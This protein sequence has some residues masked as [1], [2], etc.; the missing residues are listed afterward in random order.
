MTKI[1]FIAYLSLFF[2]IILIINYFRI[3]KLENTIGLAT[4]LPVMETTT[5]ESPDSGF[6]P[7]FDEDESEPDINSSGASDENSYFSWLFFWKAEEK[8][9]LPA[10]EL[11]TANFDNKE[12]VIPSYCLGARETKGQPLTTQMCEA[13]MNTD[14]ANI[15]T[16]QRNQLQAVLPQYSTAI[17]CAADTYNNLNLEY[18]PDCVIEVNRNITPFC[19]PPENK[20]DDPANCVVVEIDG[21]LK[22]HFPIEQGLTSHGVSHYQPMYTEILDDIVEYY[23]ANADSMDETVHWKQELRKRLIEYVDNN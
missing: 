19:Y 23:F 14:L 20:T 6:F 17:G 22:N 10:N 5:P 1:K 11:V 15:L 12:I 9:T 2:I 13:E 8:K 21:T 7:E 4:N 18:K 3:I 16:M